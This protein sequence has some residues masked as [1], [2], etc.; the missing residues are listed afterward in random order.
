MI[1]HLDFSKAFDSVL[2]RG[3]LQKL[4]AFR[5]KAK[6]LSRI[7]DFLIGRKQQVLVNGAKSKHGEVVSD[8]LQGSV[9]GSALLVLYICG[10][11]GIC[12]ALEKFADDYNISMEI[13]QINKILRV[14]LRNVKCLDFAPF[15]KT[16]CFRPIRKSV[17]R[18]NILAFTLKADNF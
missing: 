13:L 2:H 1:I 7:T 6:I 15:T 8:V 5:V 9:L 4:S 14:D 10:F 16:C 11:E 12:S 3:L 17:I 18:D